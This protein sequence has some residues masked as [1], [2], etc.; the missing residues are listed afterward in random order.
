VAT[1]ELLPYPLGAVLFTEVTYPETFKVIRA[2]GVNYTAFPSNEP[3]T[4]DWKAGTAAITPLP[5][6]EIIQAIGAEFQKYSEFW[7]SQYTPL[8]AVGYKVSPI[9]C[10]A[11]VRWF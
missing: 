3:W 2:T 1:A 5:P 4:F 9:R 7:I 8:T 11:R 6:A 10:A